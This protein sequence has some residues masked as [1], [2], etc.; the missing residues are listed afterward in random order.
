MI[1]KTENREEL[2]SRKKGLLVKEQN[3]RPTY[4]W[5]NGKHRRYLEGDPVK[6][7]DMNCL[8]PPD[9]DIH[10]ASARITPFKNMR[11]VEPADAEYGYLIVPKLFHGGYFTHFELGKSRRA[12]YGRSRYEIQ[13]KG[14]VCGYL[15]ALADQ[16]RSGAG[17]GRP[18]MP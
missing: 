7:D 16:S 18:V 15:H 2:L 4:L 3:V 8:N 5:Y 17:Q 1:S 10:D 11:G 12:G 9:G 13:R 6:F 14:S